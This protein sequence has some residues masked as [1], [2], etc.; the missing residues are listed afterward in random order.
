M[1]SAKLV[2]QGN[3][4]LFN[5]PECSWICWTGT[6]CRVLKFVKTFT[7]VSTVYHGW[8]CFDVWISGGYQPLLLKNPATNPNGYREHHEHPPEIA[9]V[10]FFRYALWN[11]MSH[12]VF[13]E[14]PAVENFLHRLRMVIFSS[15]R[16]VEQIFLLVLI[17]V[18][19]PGREWLRKSLEISEWWYRDVFF[20]WFYPAW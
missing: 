13:N 9:H 16:D 10:R 14:P 12:L 20:F 2:F 8:S 5:T 18:G 4:D 6:Y 3:E 15:P 17:C 7:R 11:R 1:W 19:T